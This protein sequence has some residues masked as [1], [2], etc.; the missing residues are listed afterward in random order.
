MSPRWGS[1]GGLKEATIKGTSKWESWAGRW[2]TGDISESSS[3]QRHR[4]TELRWTTKRSWGNGEVSVVKVASVRKG[5][6]GK[7]D[8][9]SLHFLSCLSSVSAEKW[10]WAQLSMIKKRVTRWSRYLTRSDILRSIYRSF[11]V[12]GLPKMNIFWQVCQKIRL[13][14]RH[15][16]SFPTRKRH[17]AE[18]Y[19]LSDSWFSAV[20][21]SPNWHQA[22]GG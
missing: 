18:I 2:L 16:D 5:H 20:E 8:Q 4:L 6:K 10:S 12:I 7:Q 14:V 13:P 1:E 15:I 22:L 9:S 17:F 19:R 3:T 21:S 11:Q